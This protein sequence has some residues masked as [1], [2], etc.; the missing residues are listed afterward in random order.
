M[1]FQ[2]MGL[3]DIIQRVFRDIKKKQD[4]DWGLGLQLKVERTS[5]KVLKESANEAEKQLREW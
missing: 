2:I 1:L 3:D 4:K 5:N